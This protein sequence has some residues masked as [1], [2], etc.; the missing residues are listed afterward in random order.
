MVVDNEFEV[1]ETDMIRTRVMLAQLAGEQ[2]RLTGELAE[3]SLVSHVDRA[4]WLMSRR[5]P[6]ERLAWRRL[7]RRR[8]LVDPEPV[9]EQFHRTASLALPKPKRKRMKF[10]EAQL[11]IA[12]EWA[13]RKDAA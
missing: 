5:T 4:D 12:A 7:W 6:D 9:F 11:R 10:T 3:T 8:G 2:E 13:A 1:T